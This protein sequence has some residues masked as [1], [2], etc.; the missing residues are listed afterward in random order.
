MPNQQQLSIIGNFSYHLLLHT[1][2]IDIYPN[3]LQWLRYPWFKDENK[4]NMKRYNE[5]KLIQCG[6]NWNRH[7]AVK[8]EN[9]HHPL[10]IS[11]HLSHMMSDC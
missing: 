9:D 4:K 7:G 2:Y 6:F 1:L 10:I 8:Y 5:Y 3:Q 11:F